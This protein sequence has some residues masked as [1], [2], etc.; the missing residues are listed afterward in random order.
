MIKLNKGSR[1]PLYLQVKEGILAE[2]HAGAYTPDEPIPTESALAES[3]GLSRL[4]VRR[5]IVELAQEGVVHRIPGRGT[6]IIAG[7][8]KPSITSIAMV[9]SDDVPT[10]I[11]GPF[12]GHLMQGMYTASL[13]AT[14]SLRGIPNEASELRDVQGLMPLWVMK[15]EAF[16]RLT[17]SGV[18]VVGYECPADIP[19]PAY[20]TISHANEAGAYDAVCALIT[21]GHRDIACVIQPTGSGAERRKGY[22]RAMA[23]HGLK[24]PPD[25]IHTFLASG[26]AGYAFG[27]RLFANKRKAP[28]ALF[29]SDD[30]IAHGVLT[31]A[32]ELG[33]RVPEFISI[34]GFGNLGLFSSPALSTVRMDIEASGRD[35]VRLLKER[36]ANPS[37]PGRHLVLPTEFIRRASCGSPRID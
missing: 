17:E 5:S 20:D 7:A 24:T 25:R 15:P 21:L 1:D 22:E 31:A 12:F 13:P 37:L 27:R 10:D 3:L 9:L 23:Q 19:G 29:C 32:Q 34:V 6:F 4:T 26:E 11:G 8:A 14:I 30:T 16:Q 35:V 28:T 36:A 33:I 2:I 18:P